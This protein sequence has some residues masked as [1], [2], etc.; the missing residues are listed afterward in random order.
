MAAHRRPR[1]SAREEGGGETGAQS[2]RGGARHAERRVGPDLLP[3]T[4]SPPPRFPFLQLDDGSLRVYK[5]VETR[6]A[7]ATHGLVRALT[8]NMVTGTSAGFTKTLTMTG[9]GYRAAVAGTTLTLNLGYSHP[10]EM[11]IPTGLEVKVDK[12][13][14][15]HITG[16]DKCVVGQFA[17]DIRKLRPPEPYKGK[18]IRYEGEYVRR[19]EG[20]RGK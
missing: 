18:G 7:N 20:K 4:F 14:T 2:R 1:W 16:A 17:A 9:V 13:T 5:R 8:A 10:V 15:L 3:P 11:P 6:A 12:A 19:K